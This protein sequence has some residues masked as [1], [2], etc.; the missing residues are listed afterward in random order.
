MAL[1]SD[2]KARIDAMDVE[3]LLMDQRFAPIGDPRF[4]GDEGAYRGERLAKLRAENPGA[5]VAAS[6]S[7]GH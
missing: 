4:Q 2:T 1:D 6:K 3:E 7:I 5:Y